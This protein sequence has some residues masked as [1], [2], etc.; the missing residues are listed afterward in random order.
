[1]HED[2]EGTLATL[3]AVVGGSY[4]SRDGGT[5]Q[6]QRLELLGFALGLVLIVGFGN[7]V[8]SSLCSYTSL[9][10]LFS[11]LASSS[12]QPLRKSRTSGRTLVL[13]PLLYILFSDQNCYGSSGDLMKV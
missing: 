13:L 2:S 5:P 4:S 3:A 9:T 1:M 8:T 11:F 10:Q 12:T 6:V 7:E